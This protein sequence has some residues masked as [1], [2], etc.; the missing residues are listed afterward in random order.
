M[1]QISLNTNRSIRQ[2]RE[3]MEQAKSKHIALK[4]GKSK[5]NITLFENKFNSVA[6]RYKSAILSF[7]EMTNKFGEAV[8]EDFTRQARIIHPKISHVQIQRMMDADDPAQ[9]LQTHIMAISPTLLC[10]VA[11]LEDEHDRLKRFERGIVEIQELSN[12]CAM[13][14]IDGADRLDKIEENVEQTLAATGKG[15]ADIQK[16]E[17]YAIQTRKTK[18]KTAAVGIVG[19]LVGVLAIFGRIRR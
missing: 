19:A 9:Y 10:E 8:I 1:H 6:Q 15:K 18:I 17:V 5:T 12:A 16:A 13:L 2:I 3:A 4:G 11:E 7:E 14:M